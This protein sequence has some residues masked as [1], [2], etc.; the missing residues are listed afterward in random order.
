MEWIYSWGSGTRYDGEFLN[1]FY[2]GLGTFVWSDRGEYKGCWMDGVR[3]GVGSYSS[4]DGSYLY[5]GE[6]AQDT[7]HGKGLLKLSDGRCFD[8]GFVNGR[9]GIGVLTISGGT[10]SMFSFSLLLAIFLRFSLPPSVRCFHLLLPVLILSEG[11]L[12][13]RLA[14]SIRIRMNS[15][16]QAAWSLSF[17]PR[18]A[19]HDGHV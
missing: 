3:H 2:N 15:F 18:L 14:S 4:G 1:G 16:F 11:L 17:D 8:G 10:L 19:C 12:L 5:D 9:P 6:W 7:M 13:S